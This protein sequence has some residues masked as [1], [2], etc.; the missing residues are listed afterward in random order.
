MVKWE[1]ANK[2]KY[3]TACAGSSALLAGAVRSFM[4]EVNVTLGRSVAAIMY[5]FEK[6]FD[7]IQIDVLCSALIDLKFPAVDAIMALQQHL[8]PRVVQ[9]QE[10]VS[11]PIVIDKSILAGCG[12][13]V[14]FVFAYLHEGNSELVNKH[15]SANHKTYV[16]DC[17]HTAAHAEQEIV[18][19]VLV[20]AAICFRNNFVVLSKLKM[21]SKSTLVASCPK[22]AN[23]IR[24]ELAD[25]G[26]HIQTAQ[27]SRDLGLLFNA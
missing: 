22:M 17:I 6:F 27:A 7:C 24:A 5:D 9:I 12:L 2:A 11:K 26:I 4:S 15:G 23:R 3:N 20:N 19:T 18:Q 14:P 10:L 16:D 8:A 13:S 21:S 1:S 25:H